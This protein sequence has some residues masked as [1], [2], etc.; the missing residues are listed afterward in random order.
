MHRRVVE[1]L[2]R[3]PKKKSRVAGAWK[4]A[5]EL[6]LGL[7]QRILV[8]MVAWNQDTRP[9]KEHT[10]PLNTKPGVKMNTSDLLR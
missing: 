8:E 6:P 10:T 1:T 9:S 4:G 5:E 2:S 7:D 3:K